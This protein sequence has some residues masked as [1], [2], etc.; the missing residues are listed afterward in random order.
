MQYASINTET[1]IYFLRQMLLIRT[2]EEEIKELIKK[3]LVRGSTH[4]YIGEEAIAVGVC[5][6]L[7]KSDVIFSTHR[8]HGHCLAKGAKTDRMMAELLGKASGYCKGK[9]GSMHIVDFDS[10]ILGANA[11]VGAGLPLAVGAALTAQYKKTGQVVVC[12]FGDGAANQG[13]FH[14]SLNLASIWNLPIVFV[15]ENN[16]YAITV[17][18][19]AACSVV[20][21]AERASSYN[22]PGKVVDGNDVMAVYTVA[23]KAVSRARTGKGPSLLECKTYRHEGHWIGDPIVYR[24]K[25][26]EQKWKQKD[27]I[28]K[29]ADL[30][31]EEKT[32]S[33]ERIESI[34][35]QVHKEIEQAESFAVSSPHPDPE[36]AFTDI[37]A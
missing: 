32:I 12:F 29:F 2:F 14:E 25:A 33:K 19:S 18:A 11:I 37:Y 6:A 28:L 35:R 17:P 10:G 21:I 13:T 22:M 31:I 3:N 16:L 27:P 7:K 4:L 1:K 20:D 9:G 34:R 24:T 26:E 5:G 36:E 8:G 23:D 30:L 15:C